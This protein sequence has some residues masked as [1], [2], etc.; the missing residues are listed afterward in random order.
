MLLD[1]PSHQFGIGRVE[2]EP[3]A[4]PPRH[5]C[6]GDRMILRA[7]LGDIV[8]QRGDVEHRAV[9]GLNFAHQVAGDDEFVIAAAFDLLQVA[10]AAQQMFIDRVVKL[11]QMDFTSIVKELMPDSRDRIEM[12]GGISLEDP[13]S[14]SD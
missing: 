9:L 1:Q 8:Q 14:D 5:L 6:P 7:A 11:L 2:S 12:L 10:D 4:Q 3:R 13:D